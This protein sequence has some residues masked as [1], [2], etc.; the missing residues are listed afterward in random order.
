[1]LGSNCVV[2][3]KCCPMIDERL[4]DGTLYLKVLLQLASPL[5]PEAEG[6]VQTGPIRISVADMTSSPR[7]DAAF[8]DLGAQN[9]N[10][11]LIQRCDITPHG[12]SLTHV[13]CDVAVKQ[14]I[15][16]VGEIIFGGLKGLSGTSA[17][18]DA[19]SGTS[20]HQ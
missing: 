15:A 8:A 9:G 5:L 4:L 17:Q 14:E 1:V 2:M 7:A 13:G 6:E 19:A 18:A 20:T 11:V 12:R 16:D 10:R 3:R